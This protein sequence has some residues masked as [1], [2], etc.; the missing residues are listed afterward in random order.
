MAFNAKHAAYSRAMPTLR[1]LVCSPPP[2]EA[3]VQVVP[4]EAPPRGRP[5]D[6]QK[7]RVRVG[8][9]AIDG[10]GAS[11]IAS[12]LV[13]MLDAKRSTDLRIARG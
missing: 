1:P 8:P 5:A 6:P 3:A 11:R 9:S 7:Y 2:A 13:A 10:Q 12:D 4:P